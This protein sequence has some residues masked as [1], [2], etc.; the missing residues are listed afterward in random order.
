MGVLKKSILPIG[1]KEFSTCSGFMHQVLLTIIRTDVHKIFLFKIFAWRFLVRKHI[2][3][4][5]CKLI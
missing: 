1:K 3:I 2:A 5:L 4:I